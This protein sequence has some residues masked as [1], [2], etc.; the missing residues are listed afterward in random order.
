MGY[1]Y[2]YCYFSCS[3]EAQGL[4]GLQLT[5]LSAECPRS[6]HSRSERRRRS[7]KTVVHS[8]SKNTTSI[9][10][11]TYFCKKR[12]FVTSHDG[13]ELRALIRQH[14]LYQISIHTCSALLHSWPP[15]HRPPQARCIHNAHI[16]IQ[17]LAQQIDRKANSISNKVSEVGR[18]LSETRIK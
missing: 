4:W 3:H 7:T 11:M 5:D 8:H 10:T 15:F 12:N 18:E 14:R 2:S 9:G 17:R 13:E 1:G 6:F 16:K